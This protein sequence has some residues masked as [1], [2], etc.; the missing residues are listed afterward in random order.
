MQIEISNIE[1]ESIQF[2]HTNGKALVTKRSAFTGKYHR[3]TLQLNDEQYS[4]WRSG[5]QL[6]QNAM[7]HL[8]AEEREFLMTGVT[9]AEWKEI[10]GEEE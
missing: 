9:P 3:A 1:Q 8:D 2:L 4:N 6:I 7:P 10:F 5:G